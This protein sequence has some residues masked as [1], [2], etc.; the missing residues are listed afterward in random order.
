MHPCLFTINSWFC[1]SVFTEQVELL[2]PSINV[3]YFSD[4]ICAGNSNIQIRRLRYD[5]ACFAV[6]RSG[7]NIDAPCD[8]AGSFHAALCDGFWPVDHFIFI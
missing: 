5:L 3:D 1:N 7:I 8:K 4:H 2:V 6:A